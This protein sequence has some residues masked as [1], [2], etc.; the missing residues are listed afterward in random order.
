[1]TFLFS[2]CLNPTLHFPFVITNATDPFTSPIVSLLPRSYKD[3]YQKIWENKHYVHSCSPLPSIRSFLYFYVIQ[4]GYSLSEMI[5]KCFI[6]QGVSNFGTSAYAKWYIC[7]AY[8]VLRCTSKQEVHVS[9]SPLCRI[10]RQFKCDDSSAWF[11]IAPRQFRSS[12]RISICEARPM[13]KIFW[14]SSFS[15]F[16]FSN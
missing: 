10:W 14:F 3:I 7:L 11:L 6:F 5:G 4:Y 16:R 12:I 2:L 8:V 15:N 13:L 1:M 9:Q